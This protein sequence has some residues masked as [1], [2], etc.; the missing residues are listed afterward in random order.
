MLTIIVDESLGG[1]HDKNLEIFTLI[2]NAAENLS[3][4]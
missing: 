2:S 3:I 4:K 1:M